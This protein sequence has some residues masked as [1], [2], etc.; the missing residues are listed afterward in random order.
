MDAIAFILS[1]FCLGVV[2]V[3]YAVNEEAG[4]DGDRGLLALLSSGD[5][6][7]TAADAG[8]PVSQRYQRQGRPMRHAIA[9]GD[10]KG[11]SQTV[12][13]R[14]LAAAKAAAVKAGD[15]GPADGKQ[16]AALRIAT[17]ASAE[18]YNPFRRKPKYVARGDRRQTESDTVDPQ[19]AT[20]L[21][22]DAPT[23]GS[24]NRAY[25]VRERSRYA[26]RPKAVGEG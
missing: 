7:S 19:D 6:A 14:H 17:D 24:G 16:A 3:W 13:F 10:S 23:M 11:D 20:R 2:V 22:S 12:Q 5:A 4:S 18:A 15:V 1:F 25:R 26:R 9:D 21:A 8:A